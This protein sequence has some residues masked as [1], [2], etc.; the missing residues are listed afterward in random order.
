[1][2]IVI[3]IE[4]HHISRNNEYAVKAR[5]GQLGSPEDE[6]VTA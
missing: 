5:M 6:F 4:W 2:Q 1:M 3:M